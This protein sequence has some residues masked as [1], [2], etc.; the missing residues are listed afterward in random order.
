MKN[1]LLI[2]STVGQAI[3]LYEIYEGRTDEAILFL[4]WSFYLKYLSDQNK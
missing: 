4:V 1:I 2:L 3:T